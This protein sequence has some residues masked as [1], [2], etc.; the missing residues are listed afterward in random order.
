MLIILKNSKIYGVDK[1]FLKN[2]NSLED[3]AQEI[4]TL[5]LQIANLKQE[6]ISIN[7]TNYKIKKIEILSP[8]DI[9]IY[10]LTQTQEEI[11]T[12]QLSEFE[13]FIE[14]PKQKESEPELGGLEDL[15][16]EEPKQ[17]EPEL[18]G[19]EDLLKEEPKQ[20]KSEPELGGLE[21]LLKEE[22]KQ[23]EPELGGL[24]DLLKEEPKQQKSEPELGGL[25]DLLKEE[26][27]QQEPELGGLEDLLKEE[28]K[29]QKSEPELGGLED[30][31][32]EEPKQQE[33]ELGGLEDL[34][35]EEPKQQK[36][37]PELGGL[38]D[39][40]KEEPKQKESEP[41]L[42]GLEDLLKEEPKQQKSEPEL[43]GLED[44]LKE[45]PKQEKSRGLEEL[46]LDEL[47]SSDEIQIPEGMEISLS[48][49]D[50]F[51]D[52]ERFL[53]LSKE[54]AEK[55]LE[56]EMKTAAEEL[57]MDVDEIKELKD[58]LF[59]MI[60]S[61]KPAFEKAIK[62][63]DYEKLHR[64]AHKLKGAA[65][66]LR[67]STLAGVLK[68]IDEKSKAHEDID[69]IEYLVNKFYDLLDKLSNNESN[70]T[71]N[72]EEARDLPK[73]IR[74]LIE[75]TINHYEKTKNERKLQKDLKY[76]GRFLNIQLNS[77]NDLKRLIGKE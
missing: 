11:T 62:D 20:Q 2:V 52:I 38:E 9:E 57:S 19:L 69:K 48:F 23:Q 61:E 24:E 28:P 41:E 7:N 27:K 22:P 4:N 32:K 15:L 65:L 49:E 14:E 50:E 53:Q 74:D 6:T 51:S 66:N 13:N 60:K 55:E 56:E 18:G 45:E 16:K 30:L 70:E 67:L 10:D 43:G 73:P 5:K 47:L 68:L 59:E 36:S 17:Q 46:S 44:L 31:L 29:Q 26:P 12:P 64:V 72:N 75:N 21:D 77:L 3:L 58:E 63:K 34:L 42:G 35:K 39:L 1:R 8:D 71:K 40:L 76:I 25:E 37:E 54:E 33:P